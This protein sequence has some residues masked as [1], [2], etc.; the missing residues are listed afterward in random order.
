MCTLHAVDIKGPLP[1]SLKKPPILFRRLR[2]LKQIK[3][4]FYHL[5]MNHFEMDRKHILCLKEFSNESLRTNSFQLE[6]KIHFLHNYKNK[7]LVLRVIK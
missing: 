7:K 4:N 1:P 5:C 3:N 6:N 2:M